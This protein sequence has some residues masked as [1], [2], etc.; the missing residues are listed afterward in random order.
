M[1]FRKSVLLITVFSTLVA[2]QGLRAGTTIPAKFEINV[3]N[4]LLETYSAK[5]V[6]EQIMFKM[7]EAEN[8]INKAL[9]SAPSTIRVT[10]NIS[11]LNWL[12]E[13][14]TQL[15]SRSAASR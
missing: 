3:S 2:T 10:F 12:N 14:Q 6:E 5:Q 1:L 9:A 7:T 11:R 15:L 4:S 8:C 13:E